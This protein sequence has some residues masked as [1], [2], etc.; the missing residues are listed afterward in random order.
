MS[1]AGEMLF[2]VI[3]DPDL[4]DNVWEIALEALVELEE[5]AAADPRFASSS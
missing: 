3:A 5:A 4:V 2:G 1:Y